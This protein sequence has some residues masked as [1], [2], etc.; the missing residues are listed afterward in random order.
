MLLPLKKEYQRIEYENTPI[1][2]RPDGPDW[3]VPNKAADRLLLDLFSDK[4]VSDEIRPLQKRVFSKVGSNYQSRSEIRRL[5]SLKECWIHITNQCNMHCRHCM[6]SSSPRSREELTKENCNA[7][8]TESY[9]L[10]CRIFYFTGGE[11]LVSK[12]LLKS[13]RGV[14]K[15]SNTHVVILTNLSLISRVKDEF[16]ALPQD[17]LHFQVSMDGMESS[18]DALRGPNTFYELTKNLDTLRELDFPIT[19]SMTVTR[20]NIN[21][22]EAV[23]DFAQQHRIRNVHFLWLFKKGNADD[24][25]FIEPVHISQKLIAAQKKADKVHVKIDNVEILKSQVFSC[26]GTRYDLSNAGWQSLAVAPDGHIY[27]TPAL[28]Y[29]EGMRCGHISDG[30]EK[31]WKNSP[32]LKRI[33]SASLNQGENYRENPFRYLVG[34]GDIDHSYIN[35]KK[36]VGHDPYVDLYSI[37]VQWIIAHEA[38]KFRTN[39]YPALKLKMGEKLGECP[40]EGESIYFTHS[41]CVLSLPGHETRKQVNRFYSEAAK[42]IKEDIIN[43]VCYEEKWIDH[44]PKE[45]RFRSYGCGSPVLDAKIEKGE[46]VIDLGCGTG[47]ECFIASK[48]AGSDGKVVGI[49]MGSSMLAIANDIKESVVNKLQ[50]D[51]VVF[52]KAFLESIPL[53]DS[54]ADIVISNCVLNLSPDKRQV[55]QEIFRVLKPNGRLVISDIT[56]GDDIPLHIKYNEKLRGECIGGALSYYD[57]FGL[58]DDIG[59]SNSRI[60]KGY[61]YRSVK[62]FDFY[63]VTYQA[64]KPAENQMPALYSYPDFK[65]VMA[66]VENE[67]TCSRF[68]APKEKTETSPSELKAHRDGCL[69]CGAELVYAHTIQSKECYYC[70]Q[71]K[72]S[73]ALCVQGHFVCDACHSKDAL[74]IIKQICFYKKE[75]DALELMQA[76]RSHPHFGLHG[77][78]HHSLVP[79][80]IL[81]ALRNSGEEITKDQIV[82]GVK[83][84]QSIAGGACAF[85]GICGA[86]IGVGI[87][88]SILLKADPYKGDERQTVQQVTNK[89]LEKISSY[90]APR[91]CQRDV[92]L[93]LQEASSL[94][95]EITGKKLNVDKKIACK[96]FPKNKEC[97]HDQCPLWPLQ[98]EG[99]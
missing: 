86:A 55:F 16:R 99:P 81:T 59:F 6:F 71:V 28:I 72:S 82:T 83:R 49:D 73:N 23:I 80:V 42:E 12:A 56:Y 3:F 10:G 24:T 37:I 50:Y 46:T 87:A 90:K 5:G 97:I 9:A 31:V 89:V 61:L 51:N 57:L 8:I 85:L 93:A 84:G 48:L 95:K 34:G 66:E 4:N 94:M 69:V 26:P 64:F 62:K 39:G 68:S 43:P 77:P 25:L 19:L 29:S 63:S 1:Y 91:C 47:I 30:L 17:R 98:H 22:M 96:Q 27:P 79:A 2:V 67:P 41:N 65:Q 38:R 35:Y 78:E 14:L 15:L 18:H 75:R 36:I 74:E 58:L 7:I 54:F 13:V 32:V 21:E 33:R 45:M 88:F 44:I 76:I 53:K 40:V 20:I 11:P 92:W 52:Q 60:L 70:E